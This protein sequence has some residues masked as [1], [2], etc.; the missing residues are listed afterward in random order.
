MSERNISGRSLS[1]AVTSEDVLGKDVID[2]NGDTI[3]VVDKVLLDPSTFNTLGISIDK[4]F[5]RKGLSIGKG[6]IK[7]VTEHV[8]MLKIKVPYQLKGMIVFDVQGKRVG[9]VSS[10]DLQGEKNKIKTI[11]V[12]PGIFLSFLRKE[13][14]IPASHIKEVGENIL[15]NMKKEDLGKIK[16]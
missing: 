5:L 6:Y 3:G 15:L 9:Q 16:S 13:I 7:R 2:L 12:K 1:K 10:I 4:G 14:H 8:V 11:N